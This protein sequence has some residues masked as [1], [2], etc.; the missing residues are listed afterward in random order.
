MK[1]VKHLDVHDQA[2]S[3]PVYHLIFAWFRSFHDGDGRNDSMYWMCFNDLALETSENFDAEFDTEL[4]VNFEK[5]F[6]YRITQVQSFAGH[7]EKIAPFLAAG[8]IPTLAETLAEFKEFLGQHGVT[9]EEDFIIS[10]WW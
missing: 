1:T 3:L 8:K 6:N 9:P 7:H 4:F 5:E 10:V 2:V